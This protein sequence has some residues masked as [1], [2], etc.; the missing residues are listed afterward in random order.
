LEAVK[1]PVLVVQGSRDRFGIPPSGRGRT[2]VE[3]QADHAL[4]SDLP[5][6]AAAVERW[7]TG[8]LARLGR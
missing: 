6:L 7:L 3:V 4:K 8:L 2:V 5:A 1:L